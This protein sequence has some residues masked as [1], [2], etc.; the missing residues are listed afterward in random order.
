MDERTRHLFDPFYRFYKFYFEQRWLAWLS[1]CF[2]LILS[3]ITAP[4][5]ADVSAADLDHLAQDPYWRQLLHMPRQGAQDISRAH[6]GGFFL[7][8]DGAV[9]AHA[10]LLADIAAWRRAPLSGDAAAACLLPARYAWVRQRLPALALPPAPACPQLQRWLQ[11]L[12]VQRITL[13]FASDYVNNPSSMFGHTFLRLDN[14]QADQDPLL[15]YA[16]SYAAAT[17][18]SN[19]LLFAVRGLTGGYPGMYSLLPYY[20]KV[21]QYNDFENRDLWEYGL[22]LD[23]AEIQR[24]LLHVWELR[25][26]AFPYYFFSDNCAYELL[27]LLDIGRPSLHLTR[28]F[29]L[30]TI[31]ADSVRA[32]TAVPG[33]VLQKHYRPAQSTRLAWRVRTNSA[34]INTLA[35]QLYANPSAPL[36]ASL[37]LTQQ[38][39]SLETA[40][41]ALKLHQDRGELGMRSDP[42]K[43]LS[44]LL[45]RRARIDL[46]DQATPTPIATTDPSQGHD[47][48]H[49]LLAAGTRQGATFDVGWRPAYHDQSDSPD[50]YRKGA[51]I[52]FLDL[53]LQY[54]QSDRQW[55]LDH[56]TL[57][58]IQ[59]LSPS[60]PFQRSLSWQMGVS[61]EDLPLQGS[62]LQAD[63]SHILLRLHGGVGMSWAP[64]APWQLWTL[65]DVQTLSGAGLHQA[66]IGIG[67]DIGLTYH[68]GAWQTCLEMRAH[69]SSGLG[70]LAEPSLSLDDRLQRDESLRLSTGMMSLAGRRLAYLRLAWIH[71]F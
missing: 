52:D 45:L 66:S 10:E 16:I 40:F 32:I 48:S 29:H 3:G 60:L 57:L 12:A 64:A 56:A 27:K 6:G 18:E 59:S 43:D 44:L 9:N 24:I 50:G 68:G 36:P 69:Q 1:V 2:C 63:A 67:P 33:L 20:D 65:A 19:G 26:V 34:T 39:Q 7:A 41:D 71:D 8:T 38:A 31:P 23:H 13:V 55:H 54:R 5:R 4:A 37:T 21:K 51:S 49:L 46:P 17:H 62:T 25:Q 22:A 47:S 35:E 28:R 30:Y 42:G 70:W 53:D 14:R 58:A 15:T 11:A 61:A